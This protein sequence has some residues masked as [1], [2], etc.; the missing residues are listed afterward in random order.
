MSTITEHKGDLSE[1]SLHQ[2]TAIH[3]AVGAR[4]RLAAGNEAYVVAEANDGDISQELVQRLF[5]EGQT[6][7]ACI[8]SCA[9][10]RVVPEHIFMTGLGELFCIR[11]AGNVIGDMEHASCLYAAEHLHVPLIVVLGHTNCG[12]IEAALESRKTAA[13]G[14]GESGADGA[15]DASQTN[16]LTPLVSAICE[17]IGDEADPHAASIVNLRA[18]VDALLADEDIAHLAEAG[19]LEVCGA[20]YH[21]DSGR[22]VFLD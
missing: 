18:G 15:G 21:T 22:V 7:Y 3:D 17:S 1:E 12:A 11:V 4:A 14:A 16:A 20:L 19:K 13:K 6:P 10:S 8:V 5:D 9:D 2:S